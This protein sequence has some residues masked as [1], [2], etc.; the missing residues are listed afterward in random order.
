MVDTSGSMQGD[1]LD[2]AREALKVFLAQIKGDQERVGI[3][4]FSSQVNNI[5]PLANLSE[6][7]D[8]LLTEIDNLRAGGD[9]ALLDA[10]KTG[11]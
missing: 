4:E 7:R 11:V 8:A 3:V 9:T 2:A 10:I 6:S 1:K 5:A